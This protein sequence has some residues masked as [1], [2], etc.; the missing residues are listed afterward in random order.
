MSATRT[1]DA[2]AFLG[3]RLRT[4]MRAAQRHESRIAL[5]VGDQIE[6][7][8][9]G[10][11]DA[12]L[13]RE[14]RHASARARR[15]ARP[16]AARNPRRHD[17]RSASAARPTPS[18]SPW[19]RR[20]SR[21]ALNSSGG[22]KRID[23]MVLA[24]RLQVLADGEEIDVGRAQVVHHL[25]HFVPLLA[26]PDHDAGLGEHRRVELL[27]PLQQPQRMEVARA[28]PHRRDS[29]TARFRDCG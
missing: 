15:R 9:G 28:R 7:V 2:L 21:S 27:H 10:V 5:D 25:Q 17:A 23:L 16:S 24:R 26:E 13:G 8:G 11:A 6:H 12:A 20:W 19:R 4:R 1:L 3:M 14:L 29:A 22:T 18:G